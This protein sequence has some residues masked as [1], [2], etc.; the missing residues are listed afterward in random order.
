M[1]LSRWEDII[2]RPSLR[3]LCRPYKQSRPARKLSSWA[4]RDME[5]SDT[6]PEVQVEEVTSERGKRMI[7]RISKL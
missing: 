2:S 3:L 6:E 5:A 7:L 4:G 1:I